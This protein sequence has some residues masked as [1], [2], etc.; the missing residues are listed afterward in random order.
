MKLKRA[1]RVL[2]GLGIVSALALA[3]GG[4]VAQSATPA[5]PSKPAK[6]GSSLIG[7]LEGPEIIRDAKAFPKKFS[8]APMLA[9]LVKAG[10]LPPVEKR[11][12][13][14]AQLMV[15]KPLNEI[16]K[17]GGT[18][19][20]GFTGPADH[21]NGNRIVST[22]KILIFDYTGTKIV[23]CLAR[24]G[25]SATTARRR[26]FSCARG[27]VVRRAALHRGRFPVL[28]RG[29]LPEQEPRA[30]AGPRVQID[31]KDGTM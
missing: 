28:V 8:E 5:D 4:A 11:L 9:E 17:Y 16:G 20:R 31:G 6:I 24:T 18:W 12:P 30:D 27:Q 7:K 10:K 22:D 14:A 21:E 23:P 13:E 25:S 1:V 2:A 19:R 3:S 26:R 29:H 15:V